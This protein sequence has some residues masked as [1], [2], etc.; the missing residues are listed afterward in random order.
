MPSYTCT[1][2][3][4]T[5]EPDLVAQTYWQSREGRKI[6]SSRPAWLYSRALSQ[7]NKQTNKQTNS[8]SFGLPNVALHGLF[9]FLHSL[10]YE[11]PNPVPLNKESLMRDKGRLHHNILQV[12]FISWDVTLCLG[13]GFEV[14]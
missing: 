7:T 14:P 6:G 1:N 10:K 13:L 4:T 11:V 3:N 9:G 12:C 2:V 5:E 8:I